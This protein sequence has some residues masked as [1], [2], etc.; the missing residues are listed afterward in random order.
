[1]KHPYW[2]IW[3]FGQLD[4][5]QQLINYLHK[6]SIDIVGIQVTIRQDFSIRGLE[7][8]SP[9]RNLWQW[10]STNG[11]WGGILLGAKEDKFEVQDM[12]RGELFFIMPLTDRS[13]LFYWEVIIVYGPADHSRSATFLAEID[14]K[15]EQAP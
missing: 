13:S 9:H 8:I 3:G 11:R 12:D 10:L 7:G 5:R 1:M 2:N 6:E 4:R 14:A 15:I